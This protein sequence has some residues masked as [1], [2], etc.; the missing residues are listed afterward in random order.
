MVSPS[1]GP[2]RFTAG[3]ED[4]HLGINE[5]DLTLSVRFAFKG[6]GVAA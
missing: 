5:N 2:L 1:Q 6:D 3:I 4:L